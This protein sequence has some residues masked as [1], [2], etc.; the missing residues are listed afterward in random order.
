MMAAAGIEVV[1]EPAFWLGSDRTA[2]ASFT[3]YF[4]HLLKLESGRA[5]KYG[6]QHFTCIGL[7]PKEANNR[8]LADE[9]LE[10]IEDYLNKDRVVALGEVGFDLITDAEDDILRKQLRIAKKLNMPILIHTPHQ[11][12]LVGVKRTLRVI[13]EEKLDP[14][15]I[16]VDHNTEETIKLSK[17]AG[18][19]CGMTMYP[20]TKLSSERAINILQQYGIEKMLINSSADWGYSDPLLVPKTTVGMHMAGFSKEEIEKVVFNNPFDFFKQSP[21]FIYDKN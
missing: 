11:N 13:E 3:D 19:W 6:I 2:V 9:I 20:I 15:K 12:K 1:V 7:N 18:V 4:D 10:V 14:N 8:P 17:D 16:I 5:Q 21:K